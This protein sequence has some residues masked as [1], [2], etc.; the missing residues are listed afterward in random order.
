MTNM[1]K[2]KAI[3]LNHMFTGDFLNDNIG[4]EVINLFV[5]DK[6]KHYVYLCKDGKFS[7]EDVD[8]E[9]SYVVQVFRPEKQYILCKYK[10]WQPDLLY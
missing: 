1:K 9:N 4:H 7:R 8:I 3:I 2:K 10:V 6:E 5:D